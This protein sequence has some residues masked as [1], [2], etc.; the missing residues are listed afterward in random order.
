MLINTTLGRPDNSVGGF[1][2]IDPGIAEDSPGNYAEI[3]LAQPQS[4]QPHY[5]W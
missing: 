2:A 5:G 1:G 4:A 3:T